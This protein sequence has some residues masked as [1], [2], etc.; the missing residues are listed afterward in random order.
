MKSFYSIG[1]VIVCMLLIQTTG[2]TQSTTAIKPSFIAAYPLPITCNKTTNLLFPFE[3]ISVDRGSSDVLVQKA[4]GVDHVLQVKAGRK[5]FSETNLSV[6]TR[7]G[8]LYSFTVCY[9]D[10]LSELNYTFGKVEQGAGISNMA[11]VQAT[12]KQ[13][14]QAPG[15]G[16]GLQKRKYQLQLRL[17]PIWVKEEVLYFPLQLTNFSN[18]SYPVGSLRF[19]LRDKKTAKRTAVQEVELQPLFIHHPL[20][21]LEGNS[22]QC[23]LVALPQF[24]L[25]DQKCLYLEVQE[26]QGGRHLS[27]KVGNRHLLRARTL[28]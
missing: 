11:T 8:K 1:L 22:R 5:H 17:Q 25:P 19:Y 10:R 27:L 15:G 28:H 2:T 12:A 21:H 9:A 14:T 24:T 26:Q 6:I 13:I 4:K 23:T 16:H 7:D 20:Q 3:I 18:L